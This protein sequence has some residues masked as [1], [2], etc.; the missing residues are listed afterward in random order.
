MHFLFVLTIYGHSSFPSSENNRRLP[1]S[2]SISSFWTERLF[3]LLPEPDLQISL[4][5]TRSS[6]RLG[7][8]FKMLHISEKNSLL[9]LIFEH[10]AH[11]D[12]IFTRNLAPF[13]S[14]SAP[15][16]NMRLSISLM[17]PSFWCE[18]RSGRDGRVADPGATRCEG[19]TC[20]EWGLVEGR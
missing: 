6:L 5:F 15:G 17:S 19:G 7:R 16:G 4:C 14:P 8:V 10:K 2:D 13:P 12:Q 1:Q 9:N 18:T 3:R 11:K 20:R